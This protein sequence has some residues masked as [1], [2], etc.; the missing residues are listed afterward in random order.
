MLS[1]LHICSNLCSATARRCKLLCMDRFRFPDPYRC[2]ASNIKNQ[3]DYLTD[4]L[5]TVALDSFV[6]LP[7]HQG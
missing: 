5:D 6:L 7:Y 2:S 3:S 4:F 1:H